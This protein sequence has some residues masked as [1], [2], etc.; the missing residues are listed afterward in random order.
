MLTIRVQNTPTRGQQYFFH[1]WTIG[2]GMA[3]VPNVW[4]QALDEHSV[5]FSVGDQLVFT[6][7][8]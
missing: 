4:T 1:A 3:N 6:D 7:S 5:N 8:C 2:A